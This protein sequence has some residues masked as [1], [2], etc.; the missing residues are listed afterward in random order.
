MR[1]I[2][3][4]GTLLCLLSVALT[5]KHSYKRRERSKRSKTNSGRNLN[6]EETYETTLAKDI[7]EEQDRSEQDHVDLALG[8]ENFSSDID[9]M[10]LMNSNPVMSEYSDNYD[11]DSDDDSTKQNEASKKNKVDVDENPLESIGFEADTSDNE[12]DQKSSV[13][14]T[15]TQTV[16]LKNDASTKAKDKEL[17]T[18]KENAPLVGFKTN[19]ISDPDSFITVNDESKITKSETGIASILE[20]KNSADEGLEISNSG[21]NIISDPN[22]RNSVSEELKISNSDKHAVNEENTRIDLKLTKP[23]KKMADKI[24]EPTKKHIVG[25]KN[26]STTA[27]TKTQSPFVELYGKGE[28]QDAMVCSGY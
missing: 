5:T 2:I 26:S 19:D 15:D 17:K 21:A 7:I 23:A 27:A 24:S 20:S 12:D 10:I 25:N 8:S 1:F 9:H 13:K 22:S 6:Q 14:T 3:L 18:T 4:L 16:G 28:I 11:I